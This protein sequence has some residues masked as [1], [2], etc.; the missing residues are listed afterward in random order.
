[1]ARDFERMEDSNR[2]VNPSIH[3]VSDPAA[4]MGMPHDGIHYIPVDASSTHGLL[5]MNHEY[6]DDGL[7]LDARGELRRFLTGPVG[8]EITGLALTPDGRPRSATLAIR[9]SD[10]GPIG[11]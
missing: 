3:E 9:K 5:V 8:C 4:E 1:M 10:G 11:T 6:T 7:A 2:S